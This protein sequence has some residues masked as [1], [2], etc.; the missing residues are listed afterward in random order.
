MAVPYTF[1][2]ATS[3]IPLSQLDSNF[4]TSITLGSTPLYLGNTTTT[5]AGLTLTS[6]TLTT[7]ALGT[8][9][10][11][12]LTNCTGYPASSVSGTLPV[13]NGG[14]GVTTST[15]TGSVV[16]STS[17]SLVTPV[18]GTPTSGTLTNCTGL[19]LTTGVTGNLPVTNLNSG[20]GASSSTYW[21]GDGTWATVATTSQATATALGTVYALQTTGGGT[22]YLNAFG[23]Q[24]GLN[25]S[26]V[27][28]TAVGYQSQYAT[29]TG[30]YCDSFG[31][32]ALRSNTTGN[33][34]TAI[35]TSALYSNTTGSG[36]V[37]MGFNALSLNTTASNNTAVGYQSLYTSTTANNNTALGYQAGYSTTTVGA[38]TFIGASAGYS[39]TGS[40]N[41][42]VGYQAGYGNTTGTNNTFVGTYVSGL[43]GSGYLVTTGSKN[44]I[45]GA[46]SGNQGGLD[47]RTANNYIVLSDGDG[48]PRIYVANTG[49]MFLNG[50][51]AGGATFYCLGTYNATTASGANVWVRNDGAFL[52]STSAL[53]Y[54]QDVRNLESMDI[55]KLRPVRYKSNCE[56]DD[57]TKDHLGLIADE[58]AESGFE[59][60]VTRGAEGE[61]EGFQY[62]RLTVVLLKSLQELKTIVDAQAA[63]ITAL[64]L[65]VGT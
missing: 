33:Y 7:P 40:Y 9:S 57:Q 47:I 45:L 23:Y 65:K 62:E 29:S 31:W 10:S 34:N 24:A 25:T 28:I 60:L 55:N 11:G 56:H 13:A 37:G 48:N 19:P 15:G 30:T 4:A 32:S 51:G 8:P 39:S 6:P 35:G 5:I 17:P 53:K 61:V 50:D 42:F 12:T 2:S 27:G 14:T 18:L 26:G 58:A 3:A 16:L 38:N 41:V 59:E 22:P 63:E 49:T 54:K 1:A 64:K 44:T 20:T 21:R 46:Y 43:G 36:N 52:R